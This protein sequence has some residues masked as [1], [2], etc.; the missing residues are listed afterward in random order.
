MAQISTKSGRT[1]KGPGPTTETA[2]LCR[3][4]ATNATLR[5]RCRRFALRIDRRRLLTVTG[6]T[7]TTQPHRHDR[8]TWPAARVRSIVASTV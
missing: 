7:A 4:R 3:P 5:N 6:Q 1:G 8:A 2:S